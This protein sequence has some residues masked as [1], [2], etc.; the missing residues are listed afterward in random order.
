[1]IKISTFILVIIF[2]KTCHSFSNL[3][4]STSDT[5]QYRY[6]KYEKIFSDTIPGIPKS[7]E[8]I[9]N[10]PEVSNAKS[11]HDSIVNFVF[12]I[13]ANRK[14]PTNIPDY[15]NKIINYYKKPIEEPSEF[16]SHVY[17]SYDVKIYYNQNGIVSLGF[18]E[19]TYYGQ[20]HGNTSTKFKCFKLKNPVQLKLDDIFIN[21]FWDELV[22]ISKSEFL[23]LKGFKNDVSLKDEAYWFPENKFYLTDNFSIQQDGLHFFYNNYEITSY[24]R[25]PTDLV[26]PWAK[27]NHLLKTNLL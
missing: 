4:E 6:V 27:I 25:G 17:E 8:L 10:Y 5:L 13:T 20:I 24:A 18:T 7:I 3:R 2:S 21:N 26:I 15:L 14:I 22:I 1:M 11:I 19:T 23:K 16:I 9:L 12:K